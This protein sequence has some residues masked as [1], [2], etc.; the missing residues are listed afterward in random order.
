QRWSLPYAPGALKFS[1]S[2][3]SD[4]VYPAEVYGT[5]TTGWNHRDRLLQ[6]DQLVD[7]DDASVGP[8]DGTTYTV[9]YEQPPGT[10]VH[11]ETSITG[12]VAAAYTFPADGL[13]RIEVE[14]VR[15][16]LASW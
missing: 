10:V 15:D 14:A 13:A 7:T 1:D 11:T 2:E 12:T 4:K 5:I 6:A 9:R 3:T 16:G 8:E